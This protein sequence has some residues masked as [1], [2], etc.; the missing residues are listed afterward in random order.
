[1]EPP[2]SDLV[3]EGRALYPRSSSACYQRMPSALL[4][5]AVNVTEGSRLRQ[6]L[7]I[8]G[9]S[10]IFSIERHSSGSTNSQ[11]LKQRNEPSGGN[12][13]QGFPEGRVEEV[14]MDTSVSTEAFAF[15]ADVDTPKA[16]AWIAPVLLGGGL[17]SNNL[18]MEGSHED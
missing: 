8:C 16:R 7:D 6:E 2:G 13:A 9:R 17:D 15:W 12:H 3:N 14:S 1:M 10:F 11:N 5:L 4:H 18:S